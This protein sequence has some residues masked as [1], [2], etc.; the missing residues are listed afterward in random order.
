MS[1]KKH[2]QNKGEKEGGKRRAVK[3]PN[4]RNKGEK[5]KKTLNHKKE[6]RA[7]KNKK[8]KKR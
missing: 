5:G 8:L 6:K 2:T 3:N 4:R 7:N 1:Q